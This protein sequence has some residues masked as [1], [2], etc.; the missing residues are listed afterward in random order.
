MAMHL[1]KLNE[2]KRTKYIVRVCSAKWLLEW[3][4]D[5][6]RFD[7]GL[8]VGKSDMELWGQKGIIASGSLKLI[9][10]PCMQENVY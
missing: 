9:H 10:I 1:D 7:F 5:D 3:R 4:S 8:S 2:G 6:V